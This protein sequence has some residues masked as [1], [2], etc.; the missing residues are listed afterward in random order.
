MEDLQNRI[1]T[2]KQEVYDIL[3]SIGKSKE[4]CLILGASKTMSKEVSDFVFDNNLLDVL[5][6]N[7]VQELLDKYEKGKG[8]W[9]FIGRLQTNKVKYIIDKVELIHS[10]DRLSLAE[11]IDK[12][13]KKNNIICNC[14]IELNIGKEESKGGIFVEDIASFIK[15]IE[16]YPNIQILGLMAVF[17]V[18]MPENELIDNYKNLHDVFENCKKINSANCKMQFLSAGMSNDYKLAIKYGGANIIRLGRAIFG[19]RS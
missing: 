17:P 3:T 14:L 18:D 1:N 7:R 13:A 8:K 9:H 12:C 11:E 5:G 10:L 6:E 15:L 19:E 4:D 16:N 2:V